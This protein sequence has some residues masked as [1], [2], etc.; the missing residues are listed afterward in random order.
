MDSQH[1]LP[2]YTLRNHTD[3]ISAL[4]LYYP[5][6]DTVVPYLIS[7]DA[8]GKIVIWDLITRRPVH[9]FASGVIKAQVIS[10]QL[11]S[12]NLLSVLSK[13]HKLSIFHNKDV[14]KRQPLEYVSVSSAT[15]GST[16]IETG[17]SSR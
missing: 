5:A 1:S 11:L 2:K 15:V 17:L 12:N 3:P 4:A 10:L 14:Y 8:S 7:A 6:R 13:D 9:T 16:I